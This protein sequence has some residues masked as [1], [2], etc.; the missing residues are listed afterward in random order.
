MLKLCFDIEWWRM[1][2]G[3]NSSMTYLIYCK[4]LRKCRNVSLSSTTINK[5][6]KEAAVD[7]KNKLV[8]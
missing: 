7:K 8:M 5:I 6:K 1:V 2:E 3:V 4:N